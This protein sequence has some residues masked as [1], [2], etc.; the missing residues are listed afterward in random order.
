M[1]QAIKEFLYR[2]K[3]RKATFHI[4][5]WDL[6]GRQPDWKLLDKE[7]SDCYKGYPPDLICLQSLPVSADDPDGSAFIRSLPSS[8]RVEYF[9][10][11]PVIENGQSFVTLLRKE[12]IHFDPMFAEPSAAI[13]IHADGNLIGIKSTLRMDKFPRTS[14]SICNCNMA[15]KT[16]PDHI[17]RLQNENICLIAGMFV[18][19][20]K[21]IAWPAIGVLNIKDFRGTAAACPASCAPGTPSASRIFY[22]SAGSTNKDTNCEL[23]GWSWQEPMESGGESCLTEL[24]KATFGS[25]ILCMPPTGWDSKD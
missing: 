18:L 21:D 15:A 20:G 5:T 24:G 3:L 6:Q 8:L 2:G 4:L 25:S 12:T 22:Y 13:P 9:L 19:A 14:L 11:G 10:Q 1:I 16:S 7:A 17:L 23:Q